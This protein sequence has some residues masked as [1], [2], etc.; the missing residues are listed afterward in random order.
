[1]TTR[2]TRS[3]RRRTVVA[4]AVVL[5]VLG[6]FVVRLVDIQVV[7]ADEHVEESRKTGNLGSTQPVAG[8]RGDIVDENGT[9]LASSK[10]VYDAQLDPWLITELEKKDKAPMPWAK[11]ST[12]IA[13]ITGLDADELRSEV[14]A[15]LADNSDS[16][17]YQ[18]KKKGLSTDQYLDLKEL[19]LP[20]LAL[21]SRAVRVYPNG[22]VGGNLV[23]F[24]NS[25][26]DGY[27]IEK[28]QAQC[29]APRNGERTYLRGKNGVIVPGSDRET[30]A[31][32]GGTVKLTIDSDLEWYLS[33]MIAEEAKIKGAKSATATVVEVKTGK[34]RAAAQYPALDPNDIDGTHPD[35]WRSQIFS[36]TYEPGSTFKPIT[37]ATLLEEGAATPL[38]V[39]SAKGRERFPN[40]ANIG[41]S[42][43]HPEY[44]YTLAGALIDSSNV[45]LSKFGSKVAPEVR[46]D[47]LKKFGVGTPTAVGFPDEES[48]GVRDPRKKPWDNQTYYTTTFGQAFTVTPI[49][50]ASA[51]QTIANGGEHIDLSLVESCT[52]REGVEHTTEVTKKRVVSEDTAA[53]VRRMLENVAVQGGLAD[54]VEVPGYRIGTKTGTAQVSD[55]KGHYKSGAYYTSILGVAPIEDPQYVV[56]ITMEEPT[57]ITSSAATAPALQ[58]ALT[59]VLKTYRVAP[60]STPMEAPLPKFGE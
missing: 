50:V 24:V 13:D 14:A 46:Y 1:M 48:G 40:G 11:A 5:A 56:M 20:Y 3:P 54:T 15:N 30:P 10:L 33:Q 51:Y 37:A 58:K 34:I 32:D 19:E 52:D 38:S 9:V 17:Y 12:R 4:L 8:N 42:F 25:N 35:Y 59:Q 57:R 18:L 27:G 7:R 26:G 49:Q 6:A 41:D 43:G 29:L 2:A 31:V 23:G 16:R 60:S 47:Y 28:L 45:A 44:D 53:Q 21:K 39:V 22:A 36:H 55:G